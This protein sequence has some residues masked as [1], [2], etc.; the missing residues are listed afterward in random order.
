M[1]QLL[2]R[3][4]ALA[5]PLERYRRML[6]IRH[7]EDEINKL[8]ASGSIHGTTHL[9]QGQEALDV[10][11]GAALAPEDAVTATYRGHGVALGLGLPLESLFAEI[12]GKQD[13]CTDGV[14]GSMHLCAREIGL[15]PTFAIVG[16]GLPVAAGAAMAFQV[17]RE[18]RVAVAVFGDGSANIGAFHE[19]LNIASVWQLPVVFVL[20]HNVYGEYSRWN[21]TT[22]FEDLVRRA[23]SYDMPGVQVDGMDV[24]ATQAAIEQA[25]AR[26]L[27]GDGPT[28]VEAKTYRFSGHSRSD[29]APYRPEGEL[30]AWRERDPIVVETARLLG[31]GIAQAELDRIE[32]EATAAVA[33]AIAAAQAAP[34]ATTAHMFGHVAARTA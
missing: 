26:A 12:M 7:A 13:G 22:P 17:N 18:Q 19:T 23:D 29:T 6:E 11:L 10:A 34:S 5:N 9:C 4:A 3:R 8:F 25:R 16:A 2:D 33:A 15:L 28:L 32:E 21:V 20:D 14:G 31:E 30:D 1:N 27:A 24:A